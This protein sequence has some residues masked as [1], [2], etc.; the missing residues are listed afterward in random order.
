MTTLEAVIE[1][2]STGIRLQIG[3]IADTGSWTAIDFSELP[4]AL[5]WDVFTTGY[6]ARETV[7]QCL[8]ILDRFREQIN[9]WSIPQNQIT[10]IATSALREAKNRDVVLDR[11]LVKTGFKIKVIDGIEENRLMYM[12]VIHAFEQEASRLQ[13]NNSAILE[14][15]G[16]S[17]EIMLL[18]KG[19][20]AAVHSLR[21]GTV[22]IEQQIHS[23][24]GT[25]KDTRRLLQEHIRNTAATMN[26]ELNLQQVDTFI[27]IGSEVRLAA[28]LRGHEINPHCWTIGL[29]EF[30]DFVDEVSE[31]SP[32]ECTEH[33]KI[34]YSD[35]TSLAVGLF[36][37]RLFI[38]QTSAKN[39]FVPDTTIRDGIII[40]K[41]KGP[42]RDLQEEFFSQVIASAKNLGKK[43]HYD[44]KHADFVTFISLRLFDEM[45]NEL[46]LDNHARLLLQVAAIL[47]DIGMFIKDA[48]HHIHSQ[49]I[50][51]NSDIFGL[52]KD[53][54]TI[55]SLI[56]RYHRGSG[57]KQG[58]DFFY[59]LPRSDRML[60]QKLAALLRIADALDR[61]HTQRITKFDITYSGDTVIFKLLGV[62]DTALEKSALA[63]KSDLFESVFGYKILLT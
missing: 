50:V 19:K 18:E 47:H 37:Y 5:G 11:I 23:M 1:I 10:A 38:N 55:I 41:I 40:S 16:G 20:M 39:I 49:Y 46:G 36:M 45:Y 17:T 51:S 43:Y 62:H 21:L 33:F 12:A 13:K 15:G 4:V 63:E 42:S 25:Q 24:M 54:I 22:I 59:A 7:L 48:N 26:T 52:N 34:P 27:T 32:E 9:A 53:E 28:K 58:D 3:E 29:K 14:I 8:R 31:Y 35:A 60:V 56:A 30:S 61:G 44:Q 6:V 57:P 2:G